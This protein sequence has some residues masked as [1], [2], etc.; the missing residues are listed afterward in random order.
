MASGEPVTVYR[1][2]RMG[3]ILR[4]SGLW[5]ALNREYS[6]MCF[7]LIVPH[8]DRKGNVHLGEGSGDYLV[9][10]ISCLY[11]FRGTQESTPI[12]SEI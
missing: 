10:W 12:S 5:V 9:R 3:I 7:L 6:D 1:K 11:R 4:R 2:L 8:A